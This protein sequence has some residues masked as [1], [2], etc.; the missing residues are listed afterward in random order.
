MPSPCLLVRRVNNLV[1]PLKALEAM[2][3]EKAL[4]VS[5]VDALTEIVKDGQTGVVFEAD[6]RDSLARQCIRLCS[7]MDLRRGLGKEA[8][9]WVAKERNPTSMAEQY[10]NVYNQIL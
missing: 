3:M 6:N 1:T 10:K 4:L 5:N 7:D 9:R 2:A 8:R